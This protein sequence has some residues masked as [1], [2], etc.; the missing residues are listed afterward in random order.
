MWRQGVRFV[1]ISLCVLY[2]LEGVSTFV[3]VPEV[4]GPDDDQ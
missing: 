4:G 2:D 3:T 1:T